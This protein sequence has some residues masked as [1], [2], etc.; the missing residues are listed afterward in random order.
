MK[1]IEVDSGN[2]SAVGYDAGTLYVRFNRG[3]TYTYSDVPEIL[4]RKLLNAHS[5]GEYFAENIKGKYQ[6]KRID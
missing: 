3:R 5:I 6:Y 4:F 1:M 2:I